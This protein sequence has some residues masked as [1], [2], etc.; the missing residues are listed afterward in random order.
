MSS[1]VISFFSYYISSYPHYQD[2]KYRYREASQDHHT[3]I[4]FWLEALNRYVDEMKC[5]KVLCWIESNHFTFIWIIWD[6]KMCLILILGWYQ[7]MRRFH[8]IFC[9]SKSL[10]FSRMRVIGSL[11]LFVS[12]LLGLWI[13]LFYLVSN[14]P[15]FFEVYFL[16]PSFSRHLLPSYSFFGVSHS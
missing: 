7:W 8:F 6:L 4:S 9:D 11:Y 2:E 16:P 3:L 12:I 13:N 10:I 1:T 14:I 5:S 15:L